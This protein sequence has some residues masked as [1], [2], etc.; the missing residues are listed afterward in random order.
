MCPASTEA[1]GRA[2]F[3]PGSARPYTKIIHVQLGHVFSPFY[4]VLDMQRKL[5]WHPAPA[6]QAVNEKWVMM[7]RS[8]RP[9][10][11]PTDVIELPDRIL[12]LVEIAG[13]H[14]DHLNIT[15]NDRR[16]SISGTREKPRHPNP[17]YHQVEIG[18]GD[19]RVELEL[20]WTVERDEVSAT[21][22]AGFLEVE[23]PRKAPRTV[24]VTDLSSGE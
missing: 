3:A 16:L 5:K 23:L 24:P 10:T 1:I 13:M 21:Y 12:V 11:P 4:E 6:S 14:T 20:P 22:E 19:F 18:F 7:I 15:L 2:K 8:A 17:A 9:F